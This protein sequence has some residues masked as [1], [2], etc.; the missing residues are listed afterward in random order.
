MTTTLQLLSG[1]ATDHQHLLRRCSHRAGRNGVYA[2]QVGDERLVFTRLVFTRP[3]ERYIS[4]NRHFSGPLRRFTS[5]W[6]R[7]P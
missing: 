2:D 1:Q 7:D 3:L 6:S 4:D 5:P